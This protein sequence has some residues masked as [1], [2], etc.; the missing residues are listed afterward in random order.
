MSAR[1]STAVRKAELILQGQQH[2]RE[3][4]AEFQ[5]LRQI[6]TPT[7]LLASVLEVVSKHKL[8]VLGSALALTVFK[9]RRM[10]AGLESGLI[11]LELWRKAVPLYARVKEYFRKV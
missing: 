6:A 2:R 11:G 8:L 4:M 9:P 3:L 1:K 7:G 10:L 5:N